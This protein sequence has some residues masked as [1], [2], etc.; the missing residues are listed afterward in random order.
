MIASLRLGSILFSLSCFFSLAIYSLVVVIGFGFDCCWICVVW[1]LAVFLHFLLLIGC[2]LDAWIISILFV[3]NSFSYL[4]AGSRYWFVVLGS[5]GSRSFLRLLLYSSLMPT[6][7]SIAMSSRPS[8]RSHVDSSL[9]VAPDETKLG[10][11]AALSDGLFSTISRP[12][13]G[14]FEIG[15]IFSGLSTTQ[16]GQF[17]NA[18]SNVK[19]R[20]HSTVSALSGVLA[21]L[22]VLSTSLVGAT[23]AYGNTQATHCM[24]GYIATYQLVQLA[25]NAT[26]TPPNVYLDLQ[27]VD[28]FEL[29]LTF[30]RDHPSDLM[31]VAARERWA[32]VGAALAAARDVILCGGNWR[33]PE[34]LWGE[35][36]DFTDLPG[37]GVVVLSD[38][39]RGRL[40]QSSFSIWMTSGPK[41]LVSI[42]ESLVDSFYCCSFQSG[43]FLCCDDPSFDQ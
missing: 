33:L 35:A 11:F 4:S 12:S 9:P 24:C 1:V 15:C 19:D 28:H 43:S 42:L 23:V 3:V 2:F 14:S 18:L 5:F 27:R 40:F 25:E 37:I 17:S 8:K 20:E 30:I 41:N 26:S 22:P 16:I 36:S 34:R 32:E 10:Y 7:G 29:L 39:A 31:S 38:G 13:A 6:R 21:G